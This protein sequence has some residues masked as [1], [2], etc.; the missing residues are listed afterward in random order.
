MKLVKWA[1][2]FAFSFFISWIVISTFS[3]PPFR[4]LAAIK[5]VF[6]PDIRA[7][8]IYYYIGIAFCFGLSLGLTVAIYN[9]ITL[10]TRSMKLGRRVR[11]LEDEAAG[12]HTELDSYKN[13]KDIPEP[14]DDEKKDK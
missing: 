9:F 8:P 7:F 11:E 10:K 12:L 13:L 3:Q 6:Y 2:F 14:A 1:I 5:I 4:E